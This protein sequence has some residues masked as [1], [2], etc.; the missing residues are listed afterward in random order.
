MRLAL[1]F[2]PLAFCWLPRL[3]SHWRGSRTVPWTLV[4]RL[5]AT[6]ELRLYWTFLPHLI[7][8]R[9]I[10]SEWTW[11][12][13]SPLAWSRMS[14]ERIVGTRNLPATHYTIIVLMEHD[15]YCTGV[16]GVKQQSCWGVLWLFKRPQVSLLEKQ[17]NRQHDIWCL[18]TNTWAN[19][20]AIVSSVITKIFN[21]CKYWMVT[22]QPS[23]AVMFS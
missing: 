2:S 7:I 6:A 9:T 11:P 16:V 20:V 1:L 8:L 15:W 19:R 13:W 4:L 21:P 5:L 18:M 12:R 23:V 14:L 22:I 3:L 17:R 10:W